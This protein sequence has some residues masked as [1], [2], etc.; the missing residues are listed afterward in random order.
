MVVRCAVLTAVLAGACARE[1]AVWDPVDDPTVP[2]AAASA[3]PWPDDVPLA[4]GFA[5][6]TW[7]TMPEPGRISLGWR[8]VELST[9]T[10][11]LV[12][13]GGIGTSIAVDAPA[14]LHHVDLGLLP[15]ATTFHYRVL[16][17]GGGERE[18]VFTTPG[19][20]EWRFIHLAEFH[21][22]S[23][24]PEVARFAAAIRAFQPQLVVESGD[25]MND[26]NEDDQWLDYLNT[27]RPWIS[28]V[29]LLPAHSNHV[30]GPAGN[31]IL[32]TLFQ[33][34][35]NER[36]YTTRYGAVE[37]LTLDSTYDG[38]A[39]DIDSEP[40]W[41]E[42]SMAAAR[43]APDPP[44][45]TIG[46]WH[47]PACS[48]HYASRSP[49]RRWVIENLVA[50]FLATGGLDLIL[51]GH[52]KYYERSI[53]SVGGQHIPHV[54]ANAGKLSPSRAGDNEPECSPILTDTETRSLLLVG[55]SPT[56][57]VARVIDQEGGILDEFTVAPRPPPPAAAARS[58][59]SP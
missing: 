38:K 14:T 47:Y 18:G 32:T 40:A 36:W 52:D 17:D 49:G 57:M 21:A 13:A 34:P 11:V 25:M 58:G 45:F 16:L 8:T 37:I 9:A 3:I 54:M 48:S 29:I 23:E 19:L 20:E 6:P 55:V 10:V 33:L 5:T 2:G 41:I 43:D 46:A 30:N 39:L 12:D 44:V 59:G 15:P 35:N 24:S 50:A 53:L 4:A 7:L 1:T 26:G 56:A 31:P 51:V 42:G 22:P 27:S 28:N